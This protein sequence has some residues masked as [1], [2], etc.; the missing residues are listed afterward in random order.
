MEIIEIKST[1]F[2]PIE[3]FLKI[4]EEGS[5]FMRTKEWIIIAWNPYKTAEYS[6]KSPFP[7]LKSFLKNKKKP[8]KIDIPFHGGVIGAFSYDLGYQIFNIPRKSKEFPVLPKAV[9]HYYDKFICYNLDKKRL[10]F[11]KSLRD[12][13]DQIESLDLPKAKADPFT[14][15]P[16]TKRSTYNQSYKKIKEYILEGDI[17]EVNLTHRLLADYSNDPKVLFAEAYKNNPAEFASYFETEQF[18]IISMSPERFIQLKNGILKTT[19]IKGTKPI[20]ADP[21]ELLQSSKDAAELNMITDLLRNDLGQISVPGTVKVTKNR[22]LMKA[23]SV[24]HTY[25]E[26]QSKI[27][28]GKNAADVMQS[29]F[30]GGSITGCPKKRSMEIIDE[31]EPYSRGFYTGTIGYFS[32]NGDMDTNILIRTLISHKK[33]LY[34]GVGGAIVNDSEQKSEYTET[35]DKAKTFITL[36]E[37]LKKN[38]KNIKKKITS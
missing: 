28:K 15:K 8:A 38:L 26:I 1:N 18:Q 16:E 35:L 22:E 6:R 30:P 23:G 37:K 34:L 9:L 14:L 29:C 2:N 10:Y 19:P 25:S 24:W 36:S 11:P 3:F 31:L 32:Q 13:F 12:Q 5:S 17:Y 20:T 27:A 21:M 7:D 33:R 4:K